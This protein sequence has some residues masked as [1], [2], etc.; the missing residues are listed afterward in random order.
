MLKPLFLF[1]SL[2]ALTFAASTAVAHE[3]FGAHSARS[4]HDHHQLHD[5]VNGKV[6]VA[7]FHAFD[8]R[9]GTVSDAVRV[10]HLGSD[11]SSH[12]CA[13]GYDDDLNVTRYRFSDHQTWSTEPH[14]KRLARLRYL[15]PGDDPNSNRKTTAMHYE[16]TSGRF[17]ALGYHKRKYYIT[18]DGHL[19]TSIPAVVYDLCPDFPTP[20]ALGLPLN[21]KQTSKHYSKLLA[22][23]PSAP[24]KNFFTAPPA[25]PSTPVVGNDQ[26]S[27]L[28]APEGAAF[29]LTGEAASFVAATNGQFIS[30]PA[31]RFYSYLPL[32]NQLLEIEGEATVVRFAT[33]SY[34]EGSPQTYRAIWS[35]GEVDLWPADKPLPFTATG[36]ESRIG[37][38]YAWL[39]KRTLT[40]KFDGFLNELVRF[41]RE[42]V[43]LM[44]RV[45]GPGLHFASG[46]N[47]TL[48]LPDG[49][50]RSFHWTE[51]AAAFGWKG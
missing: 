51:L 33:V 23:D 5:L 28:E 47:I 2:A 35:D 3:D 46:E 10:V 18:A 8:N 32:T 50:T 43:L 7:R 20:E 1:A 14:R 11:N 41:E 25:A 15:A 36:L 21:D 45:D 30:D 44:E 9:S 26:T 42:R 29:S 40:A 48:R 22:Q 31:G 4:T 17:N 34:L 27:S 38:F 6:F 19:Q 13:F 49:L 12:A 16:P 24:I 37:S 39:E